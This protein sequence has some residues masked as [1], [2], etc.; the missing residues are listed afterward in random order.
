MSKKHF[1]FIAIVLVII[2]VLW[3][4][5]KKGSVDSS[6]GCKKL[7]YD[8]WLKKK[9][10]IAKANGMDWHFAYLKMKEDGYCEHQE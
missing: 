5:N 6:G 8:E 4:S 7:S 10:S 1:I 9:E 2:L 3:L